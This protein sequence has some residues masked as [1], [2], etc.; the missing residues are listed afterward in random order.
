MGRGFAMGNGRTKVYRGCGGL[1]GSLNI[2]S[3]GMSVTVV[4][5]TF[6]Y[7]LLLLAGASGYGEYMFAL[8]MCIRPC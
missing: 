6:I 2:P 3:V 4:T 8:L 1:C 5:W 7:T